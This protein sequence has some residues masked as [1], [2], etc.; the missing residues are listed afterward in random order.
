[1]LGGDA[2]INF[3][4]LELNLQYVER[5]DDNPYFLLIDERRYAIKTRGAFGELI[6]R[7]EGDESNWYAVWI[8]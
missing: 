6:F 4:P 8:I 7:P 2:T 5:N 3:D 1:M